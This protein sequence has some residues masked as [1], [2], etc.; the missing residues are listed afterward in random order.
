MSILI[1][2]VCLVVRNLSLD[3]A[4]PGGAAA[5]L[6]DAQ[7]FTDVRFAVTDGRLTSV[8][9]YE[10][11]QLREVLDRLESLGFIGYHDG[12]AVDFVF[13][14]MEC[15]PANPCEWL[16]T[17][18]HAHGFRI[19]RQAGTVPDDMV[20]PGD[21]TP[22]ESWGLTFYNNRADPN[23]YLPLSAE[24]GREEYLDFST[25]GIVSTAGSY[26]PLISIDASRP[27]SE[28]GCNMQGCA[29]LQAAQIALHR[30]GLSYAVDTE[31]N[32]IV[33]TQIV[34]LANLE[35]ADGES[36]PTDVPQRVVVQRGPAEGTLVCA[37]SVPLRIPTARRTAAR[38]LV[39]RANVCRPERLIDLDEHTGTLSVA[40]FLVAEGD[41]LSDDE[42]ER[43]IARGA[44][45]AAGVMEQL[46]AWVNGVRSESAVV[47]GLKGANSF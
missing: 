20:A 25:G 38:M 24:S 36:V 34:A 19:A 18:R 41:M 40:T 8:S 26:S 28:V 15:G 17:E 30:V 47:R 22:A 37:A 7:L 2:A 27:L 9:G 13:V 10:G 21:W 42:A 6:D 33:V 23:Q 4:Y 39:G 45:A 32:A 1:E 35:I 44:E 31:R 43:C 29:E 5:F 12:Q 3:V 11:S 14:D 46:H 16:E